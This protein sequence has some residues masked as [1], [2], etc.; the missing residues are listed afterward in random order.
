MF[1]QEI[2]V[3]VRGQGRVYHCPLSSSHFLREESMSFVE[4]VAQCVTERRTMKC[5]LHAGVSTM[6]Y[7]AISP[8]S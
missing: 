8:G 7:E 5:I 2:R 6:V 4:F 3:E 1:L